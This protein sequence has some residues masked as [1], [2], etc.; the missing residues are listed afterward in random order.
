MKNVTVLAELLAQFMVARKISGPVELARILGVPDSTC[1]DWLNGAVPKNPRYRQILATV[2]SHPALQGEPTTEKF[3][4]LK[5]VPSSDKDGISDKTLTTVTR[6]ALLVKALLPDL[7][8]LV[9]ASVAVRR[10]AKMKIGENEF[11]QFYVG[12]RA[13]SSDAAHANLKRDGQL[14]QFPEA[15]GR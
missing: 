9:S 13:I 4:A 1:S 10:L 8:Q 11:E 2:I 15:K 3:V 14:K 5:S 6:F 7:S 12:V